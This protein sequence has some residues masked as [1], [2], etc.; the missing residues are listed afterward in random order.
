SEPFVELTRLPPG[1]YRFRLRTVG[2]RGETS[3]ET[4]WTFRVQP[5]WYLTA[6]AMALWSGLV[7]AGTAGYAQLRSR[8]LRQRAA[9]LE[10]RVAEQTEELRQMLEELQR[11]HADLE[12]AHAR[13]HELSL[14][15]ELTGLA[16]R[17]HL[18]Q[19]LDEEWRRAYRHRLPVGLILLDLDRFKQL[20]DTRGHGEGDLCLRRLGHYLADAV[21]RPGDLAAR[22]GGEETAVL[23]P[24]TDMDGALDVAENL[25]EGIEALAIPHPAASAGRVTASFGV[26]SLIPGPGQPVSDLLEAADLALYRAKAEGRNRV[27][28]GEDTLD[29]TASFAP[30]A[31]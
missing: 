16:N 22:W 7:V 17:R 28:A 18:Q 8:T 13:L 11:A 6:V 2:P 27:C 29:E 10:A 21:R 31:G 23:L 19:V 5:P 15:D 26:T 30:E 9:L 1:D 3:P 25:R 12:T 24:G 20:N 14:Q 4:V